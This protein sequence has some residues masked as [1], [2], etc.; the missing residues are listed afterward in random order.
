MG[1]FNSIQ[2]SR[3][4]WSPY[5]WI[6]SVAW[7]LQLHWGYWTF[8][9]ILK[10][11]RLFLV[12][13]QIIT[14]YSAQVK[15]NKAVKHMENTW[16]HGLYTTNN[17]NKKVFVIL[18]DMHTC[19]YWLYCTQKHIHVTGL[20]MCTDCMVRRHPCKQWLWSPRPLS[21]CPAGPAC[22]T[23]ANKANCHCVRC[24]TLESWT[25][26]KHMSSIL[27]AL[28]SPRWPGGGRGCLRSSVSCK[29]NLC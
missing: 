25:W 22:Q 12:S 14:W 11:Q 13:I 18:M 9:V 17:N 7:S 2:Q 5:L 21:V 27:I 23:Q 19:V 15:N 16:N 3:L 6:N 28:H 20:H 26:L 29:N 8:V 24:G 10:N 1:T 4:S